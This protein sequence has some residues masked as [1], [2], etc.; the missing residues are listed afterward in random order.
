LERHWINK[1]QKERKIKM[2]NIVKMF[3]IGVISLITYG[4]GNNVET[5]V[6]A[7]PLSTVPSSSIGVFF[8]VDYSG[9][10]ADTVMNNNG[11]PEAKNE[12]VKRAIVS[13]G[14]NL[15]SYL[16]T[17]NNNIFTGIVVLRNSKVSL[18]EVNSLNSNVEK[19]FHGWIDKYLNCSP[20]GGTP[21]G[22]AIEKAYYGMRDVTLKAKH[23]IILTDGES[24]S[25][26]APEVIINT[27]KAVNISPTE[28]HFVAFDVN[29]NV[30]DAVKRLG[31]ILNLQLFASGK[32]LRKK[33]M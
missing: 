1:K 30:F 10:M 9:S 20:D 31:K 16:K 18:W 29:A 24:N 11:V 6:C 23:V 21:L 14:K 4:C 17:S 28:F 5:P 2:K 3:V 8:V 15:D 22:F 12:I 26:T 13:V 33:N 32:L 19:A 25:G 27:C 7:V